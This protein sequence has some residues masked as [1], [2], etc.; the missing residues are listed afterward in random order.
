[1]ATA[2]ASPPNILFVFSD[3]QRWD[4]CGCYGQRLPITPNLDRMAAEGV[5]FEHAFTC[6]PVCG[7]ARACLQTGKYATEVGCF[8]NHRRLPAE[9][10]T[11]ARQLAAAGYQ[12]GYVGKWHLASCGPRGGPDDFRERAVPPG[13]RGGYRDYWVAADVLEFTS[14]SYDGHMFDAAGQ[15]VEF[16]AGRYRVDCV[17]DFAEEFLRARRGERPWFLFV[18]YIE[19]HHQNDHQRYEGPHGS[20]ERWRDYEVPGDLVD[21]A[22]DW[23]ENYP[24]YLGCCHALDGALGRLRGTLD[25]CG[26]AANTLV[27][28]ASDHGSHFRTRNGEYK[29]SCHD[30]CIRI[31]LVICGPQFRGERVVRELVS[32][33]DLPPTL[34]A[35]AGLAPPAFMR[36]RP[37]QPVAAGTARDWPAEV[38]LQIS[39]SQ[40]GRAIRTGRW[41]YSVCAPDRDGGRDPDAACYVEQYLYNLDADPHERVNLV[42]EPSLA[43]V[44][45]AL[46]VRLQA[47]MAA[48]G[49]AVPQIAPCAGS[50]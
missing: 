9:E 8:T 41:K 23:R 49:E 44:R 25:E 31:P 15:R 29:R 45:A 5:L 11:I 12:T 20:R 43:S 40:V 4:T 21:T 1:M 33:I 30:A 35:A 14:H 7:P 36:G 28:Y 46:A 2:D 39:E 13:L 37:L 26:L 6:Q 50:R 10:V 17:T 24:D 32:L 47:R 16:P 22:G 19:P 42:A 38:F 3:Q 34:L 27:V 18:S 48:A